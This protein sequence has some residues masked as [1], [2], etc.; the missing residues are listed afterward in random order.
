MVGE[1]LFRDDLYYRL[2]VVP[3]QNPTLRQMP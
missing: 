2:N 3:L 1:K